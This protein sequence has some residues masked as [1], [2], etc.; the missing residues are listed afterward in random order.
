MLSPVALAALNGV[1]LLALC[2]TSWLILLVR[3]RYNNVLLLLVAV[4]YLAQPMLFPHHRQ[5]DRLLFITIPWLYA[6]RAVE[7]ARR[8]AFARRLARSGF[9]QFLAVEMGFMDRKDQSALPADEAA[10]RR[11]RRLV[12]SLLKGL[13]FTLFTSYLNYIDMTHIWATSEFLEPQRHAIAVAFGVSLYLWM[14]CVADLT[15]A[16]AEPMLGI[17][18]KDFFDNPFFAT[19]LRSVWRGKW[20]SAFQEALENAV[21]VPPGEEK[22][23]D[24]AGDRDDGDD[25]GAAKM[26]HAPASVSA[27]SPPASLP[28]RTRASVPD[29]LAVFLLSGLFHDHVNHISFGTTSLVTTAFF[30]AQAFGC[31]L[32]TF[33]LPSP[34]TITS[35][36]GKI[37]RVVGGWLYAMAWLALT[38]PLFVDP[39]V[40][41]GGPLS[42]PF[43]HVQLF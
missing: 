6:L 20:N 12:R 16:L 13:S 21:R 9:K 15:V 22:E 26:C 40:K 7:L 32:E 28:P 41:A 25:D 19:S 14:G 39:Y 11:N 37:V 8:P 1:F 4:A 34:R 33:L 17:R 42:L 27:P 35:K 29:I 24:G 18:M 38:A 5:Q 2:R 43:W 23:D 10:K 30:G 31:L 3:R 36:T